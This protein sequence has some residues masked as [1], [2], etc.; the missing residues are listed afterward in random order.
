MHGQRPAELET[1]QLDGAGELDVPEPVEQAFDGQTNLLAAQPLT[2]AAML[3]DREGEVG[4]L[5]TIQREHV[6]LRPPPRI[7]VRR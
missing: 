2:E 7:A 6:G 3:A 5:S 4:A 1:A